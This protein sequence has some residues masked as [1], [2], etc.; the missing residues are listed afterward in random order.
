[1]VPNTRP[2]GSSRRSPKPSVSSPVARIA[3]AT[4]A[5]ASP[6]TGA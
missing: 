6:N 3:P 5:P 2:D 1:M 4:S